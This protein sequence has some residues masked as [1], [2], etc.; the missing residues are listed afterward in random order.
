MKETVESVSQWA[1]ETFGKCTP[2][3]ALIRAMDE[4]KELDDLWYWDGETL[5]V[6]DEEFVEE[7]ADVC[8]TLFRYIYLLDP[9]A[10]D[11]KMAINRA[12]KW[13]VKNGVGQ[14]V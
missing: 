10:I 4:V 14:H 12:R 5:D 7:A 3:Q 13:K 9:D 1:E 8:I 6:S 2:R 11:K